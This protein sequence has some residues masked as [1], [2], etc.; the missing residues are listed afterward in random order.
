VVVREAE[1]ARIRILQVIENLQRQDLAPMDEAR[2]YQEMMD[3][4]GL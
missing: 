3:A 4:K 1:G 2:A